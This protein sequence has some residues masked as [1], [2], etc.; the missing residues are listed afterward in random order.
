MNGTR[1]TC[2]SPEDG[3]ALLDHAR[4]GNVRGDRRRCSSALKS[5]AFRSSLSTARLAFLCSILQR[6]GFT[7]HTAPSRT[8]R[9]TGLSIA[10]PLDQL[11]EQ[12]ALVDEV[13]RRTSPARSLPSAIL[14]LA[15][16]GDDA[17]RAPARGSSRWN[18]TNSLY[19]GTS[20]Q[21]RMAIRGG[22]RG[23]PTARRRRAARGAHRG[24]PAADARRSGGGTRRITGRPKNTVE[25][26][27]LYARARR[28]LGVVLGEAQ[29]VRV[30][31]EERVEPRG[32]ARLGE[33]G[34]DG[35]EPLLPVGSS[36]NWA[37]DGRVGQR[38]LVGLSRT[39]A[40]HG[41]TPVWSS[42]ILRRAS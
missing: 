28:R 19:V 39:R 6:N 23:P 38:R 4:P 34:I 7:M 36:P 41:A 22:S 20:R 24:A 2:G 26:A 10:L 18:R 37:A 42:A 5:P 1:S 29:A 16:V 3:P 35:D 27:S 13:D 25:S 40:H 17:R 30:V 9:S 32:R 15:R 31:D 21:S 33:A 8:A 12:H 11:A 14:H